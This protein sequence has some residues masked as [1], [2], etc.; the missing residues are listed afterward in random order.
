MLS[1]LWSPQCSSLLSGC[2]DPSR[3]RPNQ[4]RSECTRQACGF[5]E[6]VSVMRWSHQYVPQSATSYCWRTLADTKQKTIHLRLLYRTECPRTVH[7]RIKVAWCEPV[8]HDDPSDRTPYFCCSLLNLGKRTG[9][10]KEC[11]NG[12]TARILRV[13]LPASQWN[14]LRSFQSIGFVWRT[15]AVQMPSTLVPSYS[16]TSS[17]AVNQSEDRS[18][19]GYTENALARRHQ[20]VI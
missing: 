10:K 16:S 1:L 18:Q 5:T 15:V 7:K 13:K 11:L 19:Q 3:S 4:I 9:S 14:L 12:S 20:D 2:S 8:E 6:H 17:K